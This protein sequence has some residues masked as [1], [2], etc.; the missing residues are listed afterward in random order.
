MKKSFFILIFFISSFAC[1]SQHFLGL[2]KEQVYESLS[3]SNAQKIK[4]YKLAGDKTMIAWRIEG[5]YT[6]YL[7]SFKK[8]LVYNFFIYPDNLESTNGWVDIMDRNNVKISEG[9]WKEYSNNGV[10]TDIVLDRLDNGDYFFT[11]SLTK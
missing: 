4:E 6:T 2:N 11:L 8:Y 9:V 10:A 1:F 3:K 7:V 5:T